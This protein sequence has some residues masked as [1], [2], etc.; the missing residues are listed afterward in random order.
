ME[1]CILP[2]NAQCSGNLPAIV[3]S[4]QPNPCF[5]LLFWPDLVHG[6]KVSPANDHTG[7]AISRGSHRFCP[8][9]R[10]PNRRAT[11]NSKISSWQVSSMLNSMMKELNL[12][13][14]YLVYP[15]ADTLKSLIQSECDVAAG[16][17]I[18][19]NRFGSQMSRIKS[20]RNSEHGKSR[21]LTR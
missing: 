20:I 16:V 1:C 4:R 17:F 18:E 5:R 14:S 15:Q 12:C 11:E 19:F 13:F 9:C 6:T 21:Q 10:A 8:Y 7:W 3:S 2:S